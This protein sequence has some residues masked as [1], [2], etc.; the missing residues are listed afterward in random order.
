MSR[1]M[2]VVFAALLFLVA[3]APAP[4]TPPPTPPAQPA[5]AP[6][7]PP[8]DVF[9][10]SSGSSWLGVSIA[11]IT[12]E[13]ARELKLKEETGAEVRAVQP[14]SP[15]AEA[16]L[17]E[18]DVILEYQGSRVEGCAQLTRMVRETPPGRT[19]TLEV[20]RDG[21][22]RSVKVKVAEHEG[23]R[24]HRRM[25]ERQRI[26]IPH[27][28]IPEIDIP[29]FENL[30]SLPASVR[31]GASVENLT[32]QLGEYFGVK[33]GQGVLVR[34]VHK[35][36]PGEEAGLRAGDVITRVDDERIADTSDLRSALRDRR[37]KEVTL[38]IVRDRREQRLTI[39]APGEEKSPEES[40]EEPALGR[41]QLK[42]EL[43]RARDEIRSARVEMQKALAEAR[44]M[45]GSI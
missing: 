31:L 25:I 11:D 40:G 41:E 24:G 13:R 27:I 5:P 21:S 12:P 4:P 1:P 36:S 22:S 43:Q 9:F 35:G 17:K 34:S 10:F 19:V 16:G 37:G 6:L 8:R 7:L 38:S 39:A 20:W 30:G 14:G 45:S 44:R 18:E 29:D 23:P 2:L 15:A 33:G 26:E 28:E 3:A 32:D 42:R